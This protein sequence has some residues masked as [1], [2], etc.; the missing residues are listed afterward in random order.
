[1]AYAIDPATY[2]TTLFTDDG[3]GTPD[4]FTNVNSATHVYALG[5]MTFTDPNAS[6]NYSYKDVS[7]SVATYLVRAKFNLTS[8]GGSGSAA[9]ISWTNTALSS[10]LFQ[11]FIRISDGALQ[12]TDAGTATTASILSTG[13]DYY[14]EIVGNTTTNLND[15]YL[16]GSVIASQVALRGGS[17]GR[18]FVGG[19]SSASTQVNVYDEMLIKEGLVTTTVKTVNG[20]AKASVKS[21]DGLAVAEAKTFQGLA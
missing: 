11:V 5:V 13:V 3:S 21:V 17:T 14:L 2:T 15:I 6:D 10:V 20:L 19:G 16:Q 7:K 1:M 4:N 12:Y 8:K 9:L 18:F